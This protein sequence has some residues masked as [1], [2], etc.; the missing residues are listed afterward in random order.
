MSFIC[1]IHLY[2]NT[3]QTLRE[4]FSI[5]HHLSRLKHIMCYFIQAANLVH[6]YSHF[7]SI[8]FCSFSYFK[9]SEI[10]LH[11]GLS[12]YNFMDL[13]QISIFIDI[14]LP[15]VVYICLG[16][17]ES[18]FSILINLVT[19]RC[20]HSSLFLPHIQ[21]DSLLKLYMIFCSLVLFINFG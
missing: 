8:S 9:N 13:F 7:N 10:Q 17:N 1:S 14:I 18:F 20:L 19:F 11:S 4:R 15:S 16:W 6:W 21:E 2:S 5:K 3:S 12:I